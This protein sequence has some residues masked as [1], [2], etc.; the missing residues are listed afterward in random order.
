M[1]TLANAVVLAIGRPFTT[2]Q[3]GLDSQPQNHASRGVKAM[4]SRDVFNRRHINHAH[5]IRP[6][7]HDS[8]QSID[9]Y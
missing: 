3:T 6:F 4:R 8:S 1:N 5:Q 9:L 7:A 2:T